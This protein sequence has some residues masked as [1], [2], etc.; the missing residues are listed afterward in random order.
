M[1]DARVQLQIKCHFK[2]RSWVE[3]LKYGLVWKRRYQ[4]WKFISIE[5]YVY[6]SLW[7]RMIQ[8]QTEFGVRLLELLFEIRSVNKNESQHRTKYQCPFLLYLIWCV[9]SFP[10]LFWCLLSIGIHFNLLA[11][12]HVVS[13]TAI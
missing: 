11:F 3:Q 4:I 1:N 9:H 5:N 7:A 10:L 8:E 12:V 6:I 13:F 2:H